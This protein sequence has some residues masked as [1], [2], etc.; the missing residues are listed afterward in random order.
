MVWFNLVSSW[1]PHSLLLSSLPSNVIGGG[2]ELVGW[3]KNY[4]VRMKRKREITVRIITYIHTLKHV[5]H[6]AVV[7][8]PLTDAQAAAAPTPCSFIGFS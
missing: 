4:L 7:Y 2:E 6:K 1:T 5:L 8:I 3:D